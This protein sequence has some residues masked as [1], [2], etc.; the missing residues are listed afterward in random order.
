MPVSWIRETEY[1][2][3]YKLSG[4]TI[5]SELEKR[6]PFNGYRSYD[7]YGYDSGHEEWTRGYASDI[8]LRNAFT[9]EKPAYIFEINNKVEPLVDIIMDL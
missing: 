5:L 3:M 6:Y 4:K 2:K 1:L 9:G 7:V 8:E